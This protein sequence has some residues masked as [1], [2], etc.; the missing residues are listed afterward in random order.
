M[1][2]NIAIEEFITCKRVAVV[3]LSRSGKKFGNSIFAELSKRGY[4]VLAVHPEAEEIGGARCYRR[5]GLLAGIADAVVISIPPVAV[6]GVVREAAAAGIRNV[7]LQQ[8]AESPEAV[9]LGKELGLNVVSG[10]CIL[11]YAPPVEGFHAWHR[12]F[13]RFFARL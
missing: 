6:P 4:E 1:K 11:M 7:W 8:G 13:N 12:A 3:G 9:S 10:K 5:L 2:M